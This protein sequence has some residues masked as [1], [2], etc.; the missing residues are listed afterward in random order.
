MAK[1]NIFKFIQEVRDE[2]QKVTWPS[3]R[4]TG[5]TTAMVFIMVAIA[6]VFFLVADQLMAYVVTL[7]LGVGSGGR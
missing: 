2:T 7:V 6:S 3:R 4:E 1:A 5:I